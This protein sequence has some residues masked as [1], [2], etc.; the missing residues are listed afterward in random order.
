MTERRPPDERYLT[1][2]ELRDCEQCGKPLPELRHWRRTFCDKRCSNAYFNKMEADARA[3]ARAG[4]T[5][6]VCGTTYDAS[7]PYQMYCSK[8]C[9]RRSRTLRERTN[10]QHSG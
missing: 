5:C 10:R 3:E 2:E 7:K 8:R 1:W 6:E 4:K 9:Q